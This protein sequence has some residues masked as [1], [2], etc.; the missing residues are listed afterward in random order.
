MLMRKAKKVRRLKRNKEHVWNSGAGQISDLVITSSAVIK[1]RKMED[2]SVEQRTWDLCR[3]GEMRYVRGK[4]LTWFFNPSRPQKKELSLGHVLAETVLTAQAGVKPV[5]WVFPYLRLNAYTSLF[6]LSIVSNG[7]CLSYFFICPLWGVWSSSCCSTWEK[8]ADPL[9]AAR[10]TPT[11]ELRL[12]PE[13]RTVLAFSMWEYYTIQS[14]TQL[15]DAKKH[16]QTHL[17]F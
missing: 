10:R 14:L 3:A 6:R 11:R 17:G 16:L 12:T 15:G 13:A 4:A 5:R 1:K 2:M 8:W 7:A 9:A